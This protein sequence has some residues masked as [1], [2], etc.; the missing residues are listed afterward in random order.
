MCLRVPH[1]LR[2]LQRVGAYAPAAT[3]F[4]SSHSPR[5]SS[6]GVHPD[7]VGASLRCPFSPLQLR[8]FNSQRFCYPTNSKFQR[9][10]MHRALGS[11]S[12]SLLLL[13]IMPSL[14][15]AQSISDQAKT[16]QSTSIVIDTHDDT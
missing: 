7:P 2:C 12:V 1:R 6:S 5:I 10:P 14:A 8:T 11:L 4:C 3:N 15:A 16:L 13:L 9:S